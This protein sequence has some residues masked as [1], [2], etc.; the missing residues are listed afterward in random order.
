VSVR[1][2]L[3]AAVVDRIGGL[4]PAAVEAVLAEWAMEAR[5]ADELHDLLLDVGALPEAVGRERGFA[6]LFEGL[7]ASRRAAR[8]EGEPML[9]VFAA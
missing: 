1:R 2:G 6:D 8:L 3:P 5:D 4:D 9:W 7:V